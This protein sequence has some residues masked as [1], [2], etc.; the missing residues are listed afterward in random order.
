MLYKC[1]YNRIKL[2]KGN[3]RTANEKHEKGRD[4]QKQR[5]NRNER[6]RETEEKNNNPIHIVE[7][8]YLNGCRW[9]RLS[10]NKVIMGDFECTPFSNLLVFCFFLYSYYLVIFLFPFLS[11]FLSSHFSKAR[12]QTYSLL[13]IDVSVCLFVF[14]FRVL[15]FIRSVPNS[16]QKKHESKFVLTFY[17]HIS[18]VKDFIYG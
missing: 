17:E 5:G 1:G 18:C 6:E 9:K 14:F 7:H 15:F 10:W 2:T 8:I 11:F 3:F 16:Q 4:D 12:V 13:G